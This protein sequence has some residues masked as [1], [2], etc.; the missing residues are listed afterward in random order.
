MI[1][2][3]KLKNNS[4]D[5]TSAYILKKF[6]VDVKLFRNDIDKLSENE[7]FNY[8]TST[9]FLNAVSIKLSNINE[10]LY[11]SWSLGKAMATL[12]IFREYT[13]EHNNYNDIINEMQKEIL[14]F[15]EKLNL[16]TND[17]IEDHLKKLDN[18]EKAMSIE[19]GEIKIDTMN[20]GTI[21]NNG[22]INEYQKEINTILNKLEKEKINDIERKSLLKEILKHP[23][24]ISITEGL[25][26]LW[27]Q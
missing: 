9:S 8:I 3:Q 26:N 27:S 20:G 7:L 14:E 11:F 1:L 17:E 2:D 23:L 19:I 6:L 4:I 12:E 24:F 10:E 16:A 15:S 21:I 5:E 22:I 13:N 18:K 25:T